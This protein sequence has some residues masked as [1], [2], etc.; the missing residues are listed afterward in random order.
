VPRRRRN[1]TL[2][3]DQRQEHATPTQ[4][5][6]AAKRELYFAR[7]EGE[8]E[9]VAD[10]YGINR[11][12]ALAYWRAMQRH[13]ESR[14]NPLLG[15]QSE[16]KVS[17]GDRGL[18]PWEATAILGGILLVTGGALYLWLRS[19]T[20]AALTSTTVA[21]VPAPAPVQPVP[22]SPSEPGY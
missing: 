8:A 12:D 13:H 15:Y 10:Q 7:T 1:P 4:R 19:M 5:R 22:Y 2:R 9:W 17:I 21:P 6:N 3:L 20:P 14:R 16:S 11:A 18:S